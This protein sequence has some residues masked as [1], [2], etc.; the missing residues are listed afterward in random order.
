MKASE[1]I[2]SLSELIEQHGDLEVIVSPDY[3]VFCVK[4]ITATYMYI[5]KEE[6]EKTESSYA[7]NFQLNNDNQVYYITTEQL[8]RMDH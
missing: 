7:D 4:N 6:L 2:K 3:T 1:V 5:D 8:F